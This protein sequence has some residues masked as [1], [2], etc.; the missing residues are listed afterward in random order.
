MIKSILTV[1]FLCLF[2]CT[3][4]P[5]SPPKNIHLS[6][7][8]LEAYKKI[9]VGDEE[10]LISMGNGTGFA[11]SP[12]EIMTANHVCKVLEDN[13]VVM[14]LMYFDGKQLQ[15]V[16]EEMI[17]VIQDEER[18]LCILFLYNNP[19]QW[20]EFA[21]KKPDIH[22]IIYTYGFPRKAFTLTTGYY[23]YNV[24]IKDIEEDE[25]TVKRSTTSMSLSAFY[26][27]S[28]G[29]IVDKDGKFVG[30]L[31]AAYTLYNQI[32]YTPTYE[33]IKNFLEKRYEK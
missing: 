3:N 12:H 17:P 7:G 23:G 14:K 6:V 19:L 20:I 31:V 1:V 30:V 16:D 26:G 8:R 27:N 9:T 11:I 21:D 5:Y 18:D 33:D 4:A 10:K 22:D 2:G 32:S 28:G 29:P 25:K 15:K 24:G 13:N